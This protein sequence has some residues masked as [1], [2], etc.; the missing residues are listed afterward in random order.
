MIIYRSIR[1]GATFILVVMLLLGLRNMEN[2]ASNETELHEVNRSQ[3]TLS[4]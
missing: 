4:E 1:W 2:D 3:T